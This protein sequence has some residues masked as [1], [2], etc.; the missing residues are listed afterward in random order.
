MNSRELV[1]NPLTTDH[2]PNDAINLSS[3][4]VEPSSDTY[5]PK[6]EPP[7][8]SVTVHRAITLD[9]GRKKSARDVEP[10][11]KCPKLVLYLPFVRNSQLDTY[12]IC[13]V[14]IPFPCRAIVEHRGRA[15]RVLAQ[16]WRDLGGWE[17]GRLPTLR[18]PIRYHALLSYLYYSVAMYPIVE[19][20]T[21]RTPQMPSE[22]RQAIRRMVGRLVEQDYRPTGV[23]VGELTVNP[24]TSLASASSIGS[25]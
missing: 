7:G 2:V 23:Q 3:V 14:Q 24:L 20:G 11:F 16:S 21:P 8:V 1:S 15:R 4:R 13:R 6:S 22:N 17:H 18:K 19:S 25:I 5:G 10:T 12:S 9:L